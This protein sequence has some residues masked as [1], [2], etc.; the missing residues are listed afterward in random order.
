MDRK[1]WM[2]KKRLLPGF[3]Q[4]LKQDL[5]QNPVNKQFLTAHLFSSSPPVFGE[6]P[7]ISAKH[8]VAMRTSG[9]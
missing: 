4:I 6:H 3:G 1:S 7:R 2:G 5:F 9:I 8:H